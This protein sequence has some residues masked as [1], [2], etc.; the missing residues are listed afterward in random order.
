MDSLTLPP[1]P[2]EDMDYYLWRKD[3]AVW[4]KLTETPKAKRGRA[5]QYICRKDERLHNLVMNINDD[6]VDC[7]DGLENVLNEID[8]ILGKS[9]YQLSVDAFQKF[10]DL[11]IHVTERFK[12]K[13]V[14]RES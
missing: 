2:S 12:M 14:T 10:L 4:T 5:L 8:K 3:I 9:Q 11:K 7:N 13:T 1:A 6:K